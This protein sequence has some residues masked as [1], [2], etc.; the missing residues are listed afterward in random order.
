[1]DIWNNNLEEKRKEGTL[2]ALLAAVGD[3]RAMKLLSLPTYEMDQ[4][5]MLEGLTKGLKVEQQNIRTLGENGTVKGRELAMAMRQF[6]S[7]LLREDTLFFYF[8]GHGRKRE[9][10]FSDMALELQSILAYVEKLPCKNK[11][12][13]L[14]CCYAG[15]A[16]T[17]EAKTM[18]LEDDIAAFAEHGTAILASC[19]DD[20]VARLGLDQKHSLFTE[21][22]STSMLSKRKIKK[23]QLSLDDIHAQV[24]DWMTSW[25]ERYKEKRQQPVF[26]SSMGGTIYFKVDEYRPYEQKKFYKETKQYT[27][28]SV[29]PM[30]A[31][32][33][34]RLCAFVILKEGEE[35]GQDRR[36]K[37]AK[38]TRQIAREIR[39]EDIYPTKRSEIKFQGKS[40]G[41]IWCYFGQDESDLK[42][43]LHYAYTIWAADEKTR[44]LYFERGKKEQKETKKL[45]FEKGKKEQQ[46][47]RSIAQW[48]RKCILKR[49]NKKAKNEKNI[50]DGIYIF[51]NASYDLL[52]KMRDE[53]NLKNTKQQYIQKRKAILANVVTMAEHFISDFHELENE[54]VTFEEM[55]EQYRSEQ[56]EQKREKTRHSKKESERQQYKNWTSTVRQQYIRLSDEQCPDEDEIKQWSDS[57]EEVCGCVVDM[58]LWFEKSMQCERLEEQNK[59]LIEYAIQTYYEAIERLRRCSTEGHGSHIL[60]EKWKKYC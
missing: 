24:L 21:A 9:L 15:T 11:I 53:A 49:N 17:K 32:N 35:K 57:V 10:V 34:K 28:W 4:T 2:Y 20:E 27:I 3:Y 46:K 39:Y 22:V 23:G 25:N 44:K 48:L 29:K 31:P 1:M 59:W 47:T 52:R 38:V 43:H 5:L 13:I 51:E 41:A 45:Y 33:K 42:N 56:M 12:V 54:T 7:L 8:S 37:L 30:N 60:S 36:K 6:S 26:R 19:A 55:R 58:A 18:S 16:R 40:A 50:Q 14:D